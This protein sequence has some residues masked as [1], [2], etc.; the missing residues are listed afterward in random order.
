MRD[1]RK[2]ILAALTG[3]EPLRLRDL[4]VA[5]HV[6]RGGRERQAVMEAL[7]ELHRDGAVE[8]LPGSRYVLASRSAATVTGSLS[9]H[10][11]GYGFVTPE[12]GGEDI[13]IPARFLRENLHG[14]RVEVSLV[15]PRH[16]NRREGR[17]VRTVE[18]GTTTVIGRYQ[19][20]GRY[21][22][23][24]PDDGRL[25][26]LAIPSGAAGRAREGETVVAELATYPVGGRPAT[27]KVTEVL[28]WPD[29]PEVEVLTAIRRHGLP[30]RFPP[31]TLAEARKVPQELQE[32][33]SA[34]RTD[35]R[36]LL[37][38]TI[39]GETAR[40]FDDAVSVRREGTAIRLW[41]SIA[42]VA[43]YVCPGSP[44]DREAY[45]RGTSVYFPDRCLPMLPEELSNGI[46]SLN[47][48]VERLA[49]TAEILFDA[50]GAVRESSFYPSVIKSDARLTYTLVRKIVADRDEAER[51]RSRQ[52]V[53]DLELML[54]LAERLT[55]KRRV[56]GSIDFDLPEP[57]IV[58]DLQGETMA[59][60]KAERNVA[61]RIIEEFM[62]AANEAVATVLSQREV[63]TLYRIH[64]PPD[65]AKLVE[66]RE[67]VSHFGYDL[68]VKEGKITPGA[69]QQF[70]AQ[71]DGKPEERMV[72][73]LLLRC[74]K[75]ARYA[76]ENVG[77]FGLAAPLYTHF[78]SPIRRYPDLVV[79][80]ILK[81]M[82]SGTLRKG[83]RERL[84]ETLPETADHT[85]KRERLAMEAER[86]VVELK[87]VQFM[88][89][90]V[91]EEYDGFVS[92]V[93]PFGLF[94]ELTEFFVEGLIHI[95]ALP[96]DY[97]RFVES[98]HE[99]LGE[100]SRRAFRIGDPLRVRVA[101]V[102]TER[103]QIDFV[104]AGTAA[105]GTVTPETET[106]RREPVRGKK[107]EGWSRAP[108]KRRS[109][110]GRGR[111]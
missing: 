48:A 72:N 75:Q 86:E 17:I 60:V 24:V 11:D 77:H 34:G 4:L 94:V 49:M 20:K 19:L 13:F 81:G 50:D 107:P 55:A 26:Q 38:V 59:I 109:K 56:R 29:D 44:L 2:Q 22:S 101:G 23:V 28:G 32:A 108:G 70:L 21:A 30:D 1:I 31:D 5:C 67:F 57:Q 64:E 39:D 91:G 15:P 53:P 54:E 89:D 52:L 102:S 27:G 71:A 9:V 7:A 37:T 35:L 69:L 61:H 84:A 85:S 45:S 47:P 62:L 42:D 12:G 90:K 76:A 93:A 25:P 96:S 83:E 80:R 79:H 6:A 103:R 106:Y 36:E 98:R 10:R 65:P 97:Y 104:L 92:G 66:F 41:V 105:T 16:G 51:E 87:K 111:R 82:L 74:M 33:D 100:G 43:H 3:A 40:D 18:R 99:L 63:P 68:P 14:D 110:P 8:R 78:T 88:R 95:T 73:Q 46:C 58:L